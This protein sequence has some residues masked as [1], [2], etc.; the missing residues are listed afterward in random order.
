MELLVDIGNTNT[1]L[2][3]V[4]QGKIVKRYFIHTERKH[5]E[6]VK[7]KRLVGKYVTLID[8]IMVVSVV[9]RFLKLIK[10]S[11]TQVLPRVPVVIV[12]SD[13]FVPMKIKYKNPREVGQDRLVGAYAAYERCGGPIIV[14]DFGTAVTF[15]YV[16]AKGEYEGGFIFPGLRL[17]LKSLV[18]NAA[19]LPWI[20]IRQVKGFIGRDTKNSMN[21]GLILGYAAMC[22][23]MIERFLKRYHGEMPVI[24][25]GGDALLISKYSRHL[26]KI[27]PDLIF[28]GLLLLSK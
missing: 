16:N 5:L 27:R 9:P 11:F 2:A 25:T 7:I 28:E 24:A 26:K 19:L 15:D 8:K 18:E 3:I 6:P 10:N 21:K 20:E 14:V 1:S 22:D 23:G 4:E 12:G 13:I 17:A